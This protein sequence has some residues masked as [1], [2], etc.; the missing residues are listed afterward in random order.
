VGAPPLEAFK[1]LVWG[2]REPELQHNTLALV[3]AQDVN[4]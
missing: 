3:A 4:K 1:I 2:Q